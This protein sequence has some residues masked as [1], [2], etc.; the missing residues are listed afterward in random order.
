MDITTF[1]R[2]F[3]ALRDAGFVKSERRGNTGVGHTLEF[4]L[5]IAENNVAL[6]DMEVAELK[7][8]RDGSTSLITLFTRDKGAWV[9][10]PLDAIHRYGSVDEDG[11]PNLYMTLF[12][13][14]G[15]TS[16]K[17]EVDSD[18]ATVVDRS[19]TIVGRWEHVDLAE[20]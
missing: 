15:N 4:H 11:R 20:S 18:A 14:R 16:L 9:I 13:G 3:Y 10:H 17:V 19:G 8:H 7:A 2:K 6:S 12:V 5:G 1:R